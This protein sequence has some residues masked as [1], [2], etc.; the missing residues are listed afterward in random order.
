MISEKHGLFLWQFESMSI[1]L[2]F[3]SFL[4]YILWDCRVV[5]KNAD[6]LL[7]VTRKNNYP[8]WTDWT[9]FYVPVKNFYTLSKYVVYAMH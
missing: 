2:Q 5:A 9:I 3:Y 6:I 4:G 7:T 8:V 1:N